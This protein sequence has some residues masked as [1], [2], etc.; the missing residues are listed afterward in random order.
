ML[1]DYAL[2]QPDRQVSEGF[3]RIV[4][5]EKV[6][7]P[8]LRTL[9]Q[10]MSGGK[11]DIRVK[12]AMQVKYNALISNGNGKLVNCP[13]DQ[14]AVTGKWVFKRKRDINGNI[15]RYKARWVARRFDQCKGIDYFET[16]AAVVKTSTNKA[17]LAI[18]AK[19]KDI[20]IKSI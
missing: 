11:A 6:T 19:K 13:F 20:L 7:K 16:F 9:K 17:L 1:Y 10:T 2:S 3:V 5:K 12:K 14:H 18:S 15:K 4:Q 8:D